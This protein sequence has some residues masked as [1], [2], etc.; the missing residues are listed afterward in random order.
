MY[1]RQ[2]L[3]SGITARNMPGVSEK[4]KDAKVAIAGL[5]GLGSN[6][7]VMLAR[8]GVGKL[9]LVD[10][11]KVE[12]SN[13]NRQHYAVS[14][15]G[16]LKTEAI[17]EQIEAINPFVSVEI[18]TQKIEA[19]NAAEI[20][21][22]YDIVCEA[23]DNPQYKA[24]LINALLEDA[25]E[26]AAGA[27]NR[28]IVAASGMAGYGSA[29]KI[30]TKKAFKNLYLCGDGEGALEGGI[31]LMAPRVLVCAAHQATMV[32]RLLLNIEEE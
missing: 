29:N 25:A 7:A 4:I 13:L 31:G 27:G 15:L 8:I 16:R 19:H 10:F 28:K 14:H 24:V 17:K 9:F 6:I 18:L 23:F 11:D 3:E 30:V 1:S 26:A 12:P 21:K 22:G 5:G 32:L 20:F 2:E